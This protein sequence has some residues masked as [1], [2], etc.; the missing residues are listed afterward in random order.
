MVSSS[1]GPDGNFA[2]WP[3]R[4]SQANEDA[5]SPDHKVPVRVWTL[6]ACQCGKNG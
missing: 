5:Q 2:K 3:E 1:N 6:T 4:R